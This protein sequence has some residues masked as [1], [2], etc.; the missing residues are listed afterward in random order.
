MENTLTELR[1]VTKDYQ[2]GK[3]P[4]RSPHASVQRYRGIAPQLHDS[5]FLADGAR[6]VGDVILAQGVSIWFNTI[7]RGDVHFIHV[8][9][10]TNIQDG[11]VI[12][13]T[14]QK[15][16]TIIGKNVS[17]AHLAVIHGCTIGDDCLIGMGAIVM[18]NA[19]IGAGSLVAAGALVTPGTQIPP[20]SLVVGSPAKVVRPVTDAEQQGFLATTKRYLMYVEGF[21]FTEVL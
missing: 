18:D 5:V 11:A 16:P 10:N 13:C 3:V 6:V 15:Y 2:L 21:D 20:N 8:G 14:Y 12:H 1:Q 7:V 17:I 19:V 4:H 9:E